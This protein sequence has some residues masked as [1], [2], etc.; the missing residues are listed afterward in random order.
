MVCCFQQRFSGQEGMT[1]L[2]A[3]SPCPID[4]L[5]LR[6]CVTR[7]HILA[8]KRLAKSEAVT[9]TIAQMSLPATCQI[10]YT[11][12]QS[13]G[14]QMF[15]STSPSTVVR[16]TDTALHGLQ[17]ILFEFD[18]RGHSSHSSSGWS[19]PPQQAGNEPSRASRQSFGT[20]LAARLKSTGAKSIPHTRSGTD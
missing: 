14:T 20:L 9:R 4:A 8:S 7:S 16:P 18:Q 1:H 5:C 2:P 10:P 11:D 17:P 6:G 12:A 13:T 3:I 19:S 15:N